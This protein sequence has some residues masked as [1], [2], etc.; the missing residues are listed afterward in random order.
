MASPDPR[1]I[2]EADALVRQGE[3]AR[4]AALLD[5]A[6]AGTEADPPLWLRLAGLRR[7]LNQPRRSLEAVHRALARA[8]L[9]FMALAMRAS[10]LERMGDP[11]AGRSWDHAL[12]QKPEGPLPEPVARMVVAGTQ[13]RDQWIAGLERSLAKAGRAA[14]VEAD[15]DERAKIDRFCGNIVRKTKIFHSRPSL[16]FY[17][18]LSMREFHPR[19]RFPWLAELEAAAPEIKTEFEALMRSERAELMPYLQFADHEPVLE[20]RELNHN[21]DWTAIHLIRNGH[22]IDANADLCPRTME[23]IGGR[24]QPVIPAAS[25]TAMFSLLAPHTSIPPHNGV[26][27]SRLLCHLPLIVPQGCWFRVGA[28]TRAW[29]EGEALVFDDTIEHEAHNPSDLLRVV[30]IFD[31]W[32]Y[33]LSA[34]ER[35]AISAIIG[36]DSGVPADPRQE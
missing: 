34:A 33:D 29:R 13:V 19:D 16:Y 15:A 31:I 8:P 2:A 12:A 5:E 36:V 20:M 14:S 6:L 11:E 23:L 24:D 28:E 18:G 3:L 32:H 27:N 1:R 17:P 21:P 25:P 9:D 30:L 10:L 7:A 4:A 35:S 22:R 26:N